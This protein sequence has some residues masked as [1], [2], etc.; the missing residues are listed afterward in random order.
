[1]DAPHSLCFPAFLRYADYSLLRCLSADPEQAR[2]APNKKTRQVK[3]GH[4][5]EVLPTALPDPQYVIHSQTFFH[6]LNLSESVASE[7]AFMAFFTGD[8]TVAVNAANAGLARPQALAVGWASGYAL[9][10]YGQELYHNCPFKNGNGYGDGR[11]ISVL[12]VLLP[13]GQRWEFQLKGGGTTPY[14]RGAD[15]RA[16]LRSSIREFL[17]SEALAALGVPTS[18]GQMSC[19]KSGQIE[20]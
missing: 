7:G 11:A 19:Y 8:P 14:C 5:V 4:Y 3:S 20:N 16:V 9:S 18:R 6:E 2:H 17:A 13:G 1:M 15:G 12:E 10:I